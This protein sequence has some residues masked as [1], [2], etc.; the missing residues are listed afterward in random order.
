MKSAYE[1]A[2]ERLEKEDPE[3]GVQLTDEQKQALAEVDEK[4]K[5]KVAEKEVFLN[6]RLDEARRGGDHE[7][8]EQIRTQ[9]RNERLRLE[10]ER[11]S[12]KNRIRKGTE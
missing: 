9:L 3:G 5:A 7:A 12:A 4:Y 1:L 2:M 8:T 11:E 6:K 10:D